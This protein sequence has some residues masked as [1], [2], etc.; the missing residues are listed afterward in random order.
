[1]K[2]L[3]FLF[4][5]LIMSTLCSAQFAFKAEG[6]ATKLYSHVKQDF[7]EWSEW[8]STNVIVLI[9]LDS[10]KIEVFSQPEHKYVIIGMRSEP[11]EGLLFECID[12][13][14]AR[15]TLQLI[16]LK[17][18]DAFHLYIRWKY[19]QIVYQIRKI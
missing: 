15:C 11:G 13:A 7:D 3:L 8:R 4:I 1:M 16:Y 10:S 18:V 9:E 12:P 14:M 2:K 5:F 19:L 17:E 6:V